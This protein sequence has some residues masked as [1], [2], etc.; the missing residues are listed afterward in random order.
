MR[1]ALAFFGLPRCSAIAFPSI[2]QNLVAPLAAA[3]E[4]RVFC[5]LWRQ[6]WIFNPRSRE[7]HPQPEE[8]YAPF[9][10]FDTVVEPRPERPSAL[11]RRL[12]AFGDAWQDGF[13]S[14]ANLVLQLQSLADVSR[15]V[16]AAAPDVVVF[17]RPDLLYHEPV[18]GHDLMR[19]L[20]RPD[21]IAL[22]QWECWGGYNDRFAI[23]APRLARV[24]G[25]RLAG[26]LAY[27]EATG[28]PLHAETFLRATLHAAGACVRP[29]GLRASRVRVDGRLEA[30][31]FE[32]RR[33]PLARIRPAETGP[34]GP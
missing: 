21:E 27:C 32:G 18:D 7:N 33:T 28:Q 24:Y 16:A 23:T 30:E 3:G 34:R 9:L 25:E 19:T 17:A 5:H 22:P 31:D 10:G 4:L 20:Q 15:R 1:I 13:H 12:R 2:A 29:I 11:F 8:N 14:L 6:P 26:A